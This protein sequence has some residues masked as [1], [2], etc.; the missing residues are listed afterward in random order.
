MVYVH[1]GVLL[2][3]KKNEIMIAGKWMEV[4]IIL[5]SEISQTEKDKYNMLSLICGIES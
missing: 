4:E 2:S 3:H 1:N 5:L